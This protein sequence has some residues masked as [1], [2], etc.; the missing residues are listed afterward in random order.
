MRVL[1]GGNF[2]HAYN[3]REKYRVA[4]DGGRL[5]I[6]EDTMFVGSNFSQAQPHTA[7]FDVRNGARLV[8]EDCNLVNVTVPDGAEIHGGNLAHVIPTET[9]NPAR[10]TVNLLHECGKCASARKELASR[11]AN[12]TLPKDETGRIR[13]D[14]LKGDFRARRAGPSAADDLTAHVAEN[15]A[16]LAKWSG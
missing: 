10:P 15:A 9:G 3:D 14:S 2:S 13:H 11:I 1:R 5:V 4:I 8:L 16:A 12:G 7:A 6:S